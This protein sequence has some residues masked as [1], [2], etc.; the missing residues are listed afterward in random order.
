MKKKTNKFDLDNERANVES[1][2]EEED[3]ELEDFAEKIIAKEM[4]RLNGGI[5]PDEEDLD[6]E[7]LEELD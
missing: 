7:E 1:D 2:E 6:D 3:P 5:D 4:K